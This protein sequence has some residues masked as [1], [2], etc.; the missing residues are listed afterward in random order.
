MYENAM[1]R[2]A[3]AGIPGGMSKPGSGWIS[4]ATGAAGGMMA[5]TA[6]A[7]I[8]GASGGAV[9]RDAM[10]GATLSA[11]AGVAGACDDDMLDAALAFA[12]ETGG[13]TLG[14]YVNL[15]K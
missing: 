2:G 4:V 3:L 13:S 6:N 5:G 14:G 8:M 11:G 12:S 9:V 10:V 15:F 7:L 1:I